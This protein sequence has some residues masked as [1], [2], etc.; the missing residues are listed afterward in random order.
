MKNAGLKAVV[1]GAVINFAL[2]VIKLYIGISSNL[3]TIYCDAVNNLADDFSCVLAVGGF[4]LIKKLGERESLRAQSLCT[5]VIN[6]LV[7][8]TGVYFVYNGLERFLYPTPVVYATKYAI[9]IAV[10]V[11]V[12]IF[13]AV[14][15]R[16]F[17]RYAD[18]D[19]LRALVTDSILDCFITVAALMS[20]FLVSKLNYAVDGV[21]AIITGSVITVSAVRNLIKEAK[22]LILE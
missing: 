9:L 18:S 22:Y 2:V 4:L 11:G 17:N 5:F 7:A 12:K 14:M 20:L 16:A 1:L 15:Y 19:V 6:A 3:L 13:M 21:F 10:T 8:V